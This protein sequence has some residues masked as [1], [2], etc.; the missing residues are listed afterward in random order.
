[1]ENYML[2]G[3]WLRCF[4]PLSCAW[5]C[6]SLLSPVKAAGINP[7]DIQ[8]R[9]AVKQ[10]IELAHPD[11]NFDQLNMSTRGDL[12]EE[13]SR[14]AV[15]TKRVVSFYS[16]EDLDSSSDEG[17]LWAVVSADSTQGTD[18]LYS[19]ENSDGIDQSSQK[20]NRLV[21][22]LALSI[23]DEKA[24]SIAR[25]FLACCDRA[26]SG[27]T[28][29]DDAGL[30]HSIERYYIRIYGDVWRALE[31][32]SQWWEGYERTPVPLTPTVVVKGGVRHIIL[33][34]LI[35]SFGMHPQLQRWDIAVAH[36]GAVRVL[37]VEA[38]FP[39]RNRWLSYDFRSTMAPQIH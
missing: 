3:K 28:V 30:R 9:E 26:A 12:E 2:H 5:L 4:Y 38:V 19:F 6:F 1:M 15:K 10:A 37:A 16:F 35:L 18:E 21:A 25:F 31:A 32:G 8:Q 13:L 22:H 34:R 23:P 11:A 39:K 24:L 36:D 7:S 20:F 29:V 14:I 17:S 27:E 33:E